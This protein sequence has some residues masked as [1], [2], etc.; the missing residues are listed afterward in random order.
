M[1]YMKY[2]LKITWRKYFILYSRTDWRKGA[3]IKIKFKNL[4]L[5]F[6]FAGNIINFFL[7]ILIKV[8]DKNIFPF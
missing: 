4:T 1:S 7:T 6:T 2:T 8:L 3:R 5:F